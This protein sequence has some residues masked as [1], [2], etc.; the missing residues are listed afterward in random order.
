MDDYESCLDGILF[1]EVAE[2]LYNEAAE[3]DDMGDIIDTIAGIG[4]DGGIGY[5]SDNLGYDSKNLGYPSDNLG[6][7]KNNLGYSKKE[8]DIFYDPNTIYSK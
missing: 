2:D 1:I 7:K 3:A 4:Y 5:P 6:Y 8:Y